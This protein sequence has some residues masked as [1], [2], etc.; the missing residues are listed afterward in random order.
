MEEI[1]QKKDYTQGHLRQ[2]IQERKQAG[3]TCRVICEELSIWSTR[4]VSKWANAESII[5]RSSAPLKPYREYD[6]TELYYLYA[7]R[8]YLWLSWDSCGDRLLEDYNIVIKRWS[9]F[10]YLNAR[11]MTKKEKPKRGKFKEYEPGYLHI[12]ISYWPTIWGK[13]AY[14]YVAIDRATRLMYLEIHE[15]KKAETAKTFL[16]NTIS[17]LPIK[18]ITHILTDNGKEFTLH[19][20]LWKHNLEGAFDVV[21]RELEI[22]H[23]LTEPYSPRTNGMV[24]KC[25]D[26]IKSNTVG[27]QE[28]PTREIMIKQ[29]LSFMLYYNLYRRHGGLVKEGKWRTPFDA[30]TYY[31]KLRPE[32]FKETPKEFKERLYIFAKEKW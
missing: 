14:I 21:C 26:T 18:R 15:D 10:Y 25:N 11:G 22:E 2:V 6:F 17:F 16:K 8:K 32:L 31:Y 27:V 29:I 4:T 24:E 7:I 30:L 20:H 1:Y 23:R 3:K 13:R 9:I 19:N 5:S 28:Y 12:D